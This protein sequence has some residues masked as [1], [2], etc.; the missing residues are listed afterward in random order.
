MKKTLLLTTLLAGVSLIPQAQNKISLSGQ[1][2]IANLEE[3]AKANKTQSVKE[4]ESYAAFVTLKE[5]YDSSVL[6]GYDAEIQCDFGTLLVVSATVPVLEAISQMEEV[7]YVEFGSK[8]NI[9]MDFARPSGNV[10]AAL[11]GFEYNGETVT[12]DGTGVVAGLMDTG[13]QPGHLNFKDKDGASRVQRLFYFRSTNGTCTTYTPSMLKNFT[14]ENKDESHATHVGG[15]MAGSYNGLG[16]FMKVSSASGNSASKRTDQPIPFY[17][18][19]TNAD[20]AFSVGGLY[21]ANITNGVTKIIEYAESQGQPCVVN[22]SLGSTIGPHDG[23]DGYGRAMSELGKR[24]IICMSAGNDGDAPIS[25]CEDLNADNEYSLKTM[26]V[27]NKANGFVDVWTNSSEPIT[28]SWMIYNTANRTFTDI[29]TLTGATS[30]QTVSNLGNSFS[31]SIQISSEVNSINKRYHVQSY[32][33][34]S[35]KTSTG[36]RLALVISGSEG[37]KVWIYG[38]TGSNGGTQFTSNSVVGFTDGSADNSIN[39]ACCGDNI[40]SVGAYTSRDTWGQFNS[41]NGAYYIPGTKVNT[42]ASFS[43]YGTNYQGVD[44]PLVVAPGQQIISS[45]NRYYVDSKGTAESMTG[46]ADNDGNEDYWG[47]MQGTSMSCPFVSGVVAL[48]LQANPDLNFNDIL[49]VINNSSTYSPLQMKPKIRWGA[50]KINAV[51]GLE[52]ILT[53]KPGAIGNVMADVKGRLLVTTDENGV[54]VAFADETAF[55]VQ[56]IDLQGRVV[57][58]GKGYDGTA[59][60][61]GSTVSKGVYV[62]CVSTPNNRVTRKVALR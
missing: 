45:F 31:G 58:A 38:Q 48:W 20:L 30:Q 16:T 18:V 46:K 40:I 61:D 5:G 17:G 26:F 3:A 1:F 11:D 22:L 43:S 56:L 42:I 54:N 29:V 57:A 55:D 33:N 21:D 39:N 49:D 19:A 59:H 51:K 47:P 12:F 53:N 50:G 8:Q 4:A 32:L 13:M 27:D 15:I 24:A 36:L 25:I 62:V 28:L 35:P 44:L 23:S 37:Q 14:T 10:D 52:W 34:V 9:D 7:V 60:I 6:T 41:P 2:I